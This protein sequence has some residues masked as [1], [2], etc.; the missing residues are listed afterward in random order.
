MKVL[1]ADKFEAEG[2]Q[3]LKEI[4]SEVEIDPSLK[5]GSLKD[6]VASFQPDIL[7]VRSTKVPADIQDAGKNLKI[8]IRAGSGYDTI[9]TAHAA[10]KKIHVANCPGMNAVAVAE[11][12]MGL[13]ISLDRRIADNVADLR[14]HKWRKKE[15]SKACGLKNSTLGIIG[16]GRIGSAVAKRA[17]AFEMKVLYFDVVPDLKP[18]DHPDCK[19]AAVDEIFKQADVIT[20]HVPG[21]GDTKHLVNADRLAMMKP[22]SLLINTS[23]ASV[24]D[25]PALIKALKD[26]K[27]RGAGVDVYDNEPAADAP[28]VESPL[29]D[30]PTLYGTHHIGASTD[31]A[32]LAVADEVVRIVREFKN[33]GKV[34]NCVNM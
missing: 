26:G 23:R 24:I 32:Q 10:E 34:L 16:V 13:M 27:I 11:L 12:V 6:K 14:S 1:I 9:D 7:I 5:E 2:L 15:Y 21:T 31:Q 17:L 33:T 19:R 22:N 30:V 18:A 29:A 8:V 28:A 25:E 3:Q 4:A 20:L